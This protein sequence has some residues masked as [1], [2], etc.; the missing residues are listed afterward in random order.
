MKHFSF[1]FIVLGILSFI[2]VGIAY[3]IAL[4]N[5]INPISNY[6]VFFFST[7]MGSFSSTY[8]KCRYASVITVGTNWAT[9]FQLSCPEG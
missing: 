1:C 8:M 3:W 6:Q 5:E 4:K 2:S 9:T 7:T